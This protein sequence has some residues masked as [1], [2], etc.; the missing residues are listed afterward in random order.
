MKKIYFIISFLMY[1]GANAQQD[2][3][4]TQYIFNHMYLNPG[5]AGSENLTR[6]QVIHRT[7][8]LG[9]QSTFD[10]GGSPITQV[11]TAN[12]PLKMIKSGVGIHFVNDR[13]GVSTSRNV[14]LSYAYHISVGESQLAI[15]VR[16]G[17]ASR[18]VDYSRLRAR[19]DND[20][21]LS[22]GR[23]SQSGL[24]VGAG[25]YFYN[26]SYSLGIAVN[27]INEPTYSLGTQTAKNTLR[28]SYNMTGSVLVG[29]SYTMNLTPMFVIKSDLNTVSA[30]V[31]ALATYDERYWAGA[32][33]RWGDA[34]SLL[35]G[36]NLLDGNLRV[37]YAIDAVVIGSNAKSATSHEVLLS[38]TLS[39]PRAGKKSIIRTPRYRY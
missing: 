10:D 36:A 2:P 21:L 28:R 6:F 33:Y 27:H 31:G 8:Y 5:A 30:E 12:V 1:L 7:Q 14:Q 19:D 15:G 23:I 9:Y 18:G 13:I 37:G 11:I 25:L 24:D 38:Y 16:G 26:P 32:S 4:F 22:T 34:A 39:P 29:L 20:P 3:Q 35:L 17:M